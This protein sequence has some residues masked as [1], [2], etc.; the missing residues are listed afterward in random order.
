MIVVYASVARILLKHQVGEDFFQ[1]DR[2]T[3]VET[4]TVHS[5][6]D[7]ADTEESEGYGRID[8]IGKDAEVE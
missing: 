8:G 3:H 2:I 7:K 4:R 5:G 6:E 1:L